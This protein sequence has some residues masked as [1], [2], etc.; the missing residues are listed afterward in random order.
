MERFSNH[1]RYVQLV[2]SLDTGIALAGSNVFHLVMGDPPVM[3]HYFKIVKC[4]KI[5]N[6]QPTIVFDELRFNSLVVLYLL[7]VYF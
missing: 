2:Q 4:K 1:S 7:I 3:G 5:C 6:N